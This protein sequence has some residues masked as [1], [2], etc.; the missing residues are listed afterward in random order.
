MA[1]ASASF[2]ACSSRSI[3]VAD[4]ADRILACSNPQK[5]GTLLTPRVPLKAL[6]ELGPFDR[7]LAVLTG[8]SD[9]ETRAELGV[10]NPTL[11]GHKLRVFTIQVL[12]SPVLL[13]D[14]VLPELRRAALASLP[15]LGLTLL[16]A[17]LAAG[18]ALRSLAGISA[19]IDRI[20]SGEAAEA[21]PAPLSSSRELARVEEKLR[22]LGEQFRGAQS[23]ASVLRGSVERMLE[24]LEEAILVFNSSGRL[25]VCSE[26]VERLLHQGR[27][28]I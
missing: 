8:H 16:V 9:Y 21:E 19:T 3:A 2:C 11:A 15:L 25:I 6:V 24:S 4:Q 18:I 17:W 5:T 7:F 13:R 12:V 23:G 28:E 27:E 10:D 1:A 22:L 20:A 14:S 26:R